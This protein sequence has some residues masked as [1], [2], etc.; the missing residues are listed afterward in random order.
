MDFLL[1]NPLA[2]MYGP[3]FLGVYAVLI[4]VSIVS[5][6]V[7]RSQADKTEQLSPPAIPPQFDAFE[8]AYLRGGINELA[9]AVIFSLMK[10]GL[11]EVSGDKSSGMLRSTDA[12]MPGDLSAIEKDALGWVGGS[13]EVKEVFNAKSGLVKQ[14]ES[15]GYHYQYSLEERNLLPGEDIQNAIKRI[16]HIAAFT[17]AAVGGYKILTAVAHGNFNIFFTILLGVIGLGVI[18]AVSRP[19][20]IT[21]LGKAYL[22]RLQLAFEDI[23]N[24]TLAEKIGTVPTLA[25]AQGGYAAV[26]PLMLS[27]GIFGTGVLAGTA[28][29]GYNDAFHRSQQ[30]GGGTSG[31]GSACGSCSSSGGDGGGGCG[32]CGGGCGG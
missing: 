18:F 12:P 11:I 20:R 30:N 21:K 26:D 28:F 6:A 1:D 27:V 3:L 4:V 8:I 32:G 10:R 7:Y 13:R 29:S 17:V 16:G 19:P 5:V 25:G 14:L 24:P 15:R 2:T 23:R 31:C 22:K 9:R